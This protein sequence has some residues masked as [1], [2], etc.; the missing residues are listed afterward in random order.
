MM[1]KKAMKV[2][3]CSA[4]IAAAVIATGHSEEET[5]RKS[6]LKVGMECA[7]A[8]YNWSQS[9]PEGG[10]VRIAGSTEYAY[11]Y[12]VIIAKKL[13]DEMDME[14]EVYKIEWDGL[15][16]AVV[17]G[18]VDAAV[19][20]MAITAKRK[21]SVDFTV[22]YYYANV[23]A[24]VRKDSPQANA[25]CLAD[26]RGSSATSQLNTVWYNK[27]DQIPDVEKLP[28]LDTVPSMIV[29]LQSSKCDVLIVDIPTAKAAEFANPELMMLNF[30]EGRGFIT[31]R[32][33]VEI[34]IA[35]QKG[36]TELVDAMNAIL[37][38]MTDADRQAIMDEAI[39][40][41]PLMQS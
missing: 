21:E 1:L 26:L 24:L 4:V 14:L 3:L 27:V 2:A 6:V 39:R 18:K 34:G 41:Q 8:P 15:P 13:A 19:A 11:G 32:E 28:A 29:A 37:I 5:P 40:K 30:P 36:N 16:P 31:S 12:D 35:I 25:K 20:A 38:E 7:S 23:V 33:D 17:T 9:T 22:P 10:G